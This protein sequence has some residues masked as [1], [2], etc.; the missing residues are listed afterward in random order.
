M[1]ILVMMVMAVVFPLL[2]LV[3]SEV[4]ELFTDKGL[5]VNDKPSKFDGAKFS[6]KKLLTY[7]LGYS[8]LCLSKRSSDTK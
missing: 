8:I 6:S 2:A 5:E 3:V 1:I 7:K 4:V